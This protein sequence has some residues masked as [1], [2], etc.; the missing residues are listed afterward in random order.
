M[1]GD[2]P[3]P[4]VL[5]L[6][7]LG[8]ADLSAQVLTLVG[9]LAAYGVPVTLAAPLNLRQREGLS[10]RGARW[11]RLELG[12][13][14]LA[15]VPAGAVRQ[16]TRL[17]SARPP[18]LLHVHDLPSLRMAERMLAAVPAAARPRLVASIP[19]PPLRAGLEEIW[20]WRRHY[21]VLR[22]AAALVAASSVEAQSLR[23]LAGVPA[24]RVHVVYP[25]LEAAPRPSLAQAGA[26][27]RTLG[28]G[29][30]T[31]VVGLLTDFQDPAAELFLRAA[32]SVVAE[33]P[34]VDFA[35]LGEGPGR[36]AAE[37]LA[38]RER[39]GGAVVFTGRPWSL[40][41]ALSVLNVLVV[42]SDTAGGP[43]AALQALN[44]GVP[45][46]AAGVGALG[47][48]LPGLPGATLLPRSDVPAL[49]A[50]LR[51][52]L[53]LVG[54]GREGDL[55]DPDAGPR[56]PLERWLVSTEAWD[57]DLSW[58]SAP[59]SAPGVQ[60]LEQA[61]RGFRPEGVV[62]QVRDLYREVLGEPRRAGG[63]G[64]AR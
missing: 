4:T 24:S 56:L 28:L 45:V 43:P 8:D 38:H 41:Q 6:A 59:R 9:G 1:T 54:E 10:R 36:A 19:R 37:A 20:H 63:G 18:E 14:P 29:G 39:I 5:H 16:L 30:Q 64:R 27:R 55:R 44:Y 12:G 21:R 51:A 61:L 46:V 17:V 62:P 31:A 34:N 60:A 42:L 35:L 3:E 52:A 49:V 22:Q 48:L 50:A 26:V 47:E 57:L 11:V 25:L 13:D 33:L 40:T 7:A 53:H 32:A 23:R 2:A 15:P 58:Q